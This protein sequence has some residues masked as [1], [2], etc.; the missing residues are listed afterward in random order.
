MGDEGRVLPGYPNP[1]T[2]GIVLGDQ[3]GRRTRHDEGGCSGATL[4]RD[5]RIV[6]DCTPWTLPGTLSGTIIL[7]RTLPMTLHGTLLDLLL[8]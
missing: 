2:A 4:A 3:A 5:S 8:P 7:P 6:P 1:V